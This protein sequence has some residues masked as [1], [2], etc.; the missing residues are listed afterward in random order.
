MKKFTDERIITKGCSWGL[1]APEVVS[2]YELLI[3]AEALELGGRS[4]LNQAKKRRPKGSTKI[5]KSVQEIEQ[6]KTGNL[7]IFLN[8]EQVE[9][10]CCLDLDDRKVDTMLF[11]AMEDTTLLHGVFI[12]ESPKGWHVFTDNAPAR[13]V[14]R[15]IASTGFARKCELLSKHVVF[16]EHKRSIFLQEGPGKGYSTFSP[17]C[18]KVG[19]DGDSVVFSSPQTAL[20]SYLRE[21][22]LPKNFK[23]LCESAYPEGMI[24]EGERNDVLFNY[25][26]DQKARQHFATGNF[27][28]KKTIID[29]MADL[30]CNPPYNEDRSGLYGSED[31][32]TFENF[33]KKTDEKMDSSWVSCEALVERLSGMLYHLCDQGT[34]VVWEN[35]T[36]VRKFTEAEVH[37]FIACKCDEY[38]LP[39]RFKP[40]ASELRAIQSSLSTSVTTNYQSFMEG[41]EG[42]A[43]RNGFLGLATGHLL[44]P[45]PEQ[46]SLG[47]VELDYDPDAWISR[48]TRNVLR[49]LVGG[50]REAL[51]SL[52]VMI[53]CCLS[54][55]PRLNTGFI[56]VGPPKTGKSSLL[57]ALRRALGAMKATVLPSNQLSIF[58]AGALLDQNVAMIHDL[59]ALDAELRDAVRQALGRDFL[60]AR[61]KH[62]PSIYFKFE[63]TIIMTSNFSLSELLLDEPD[64]GFC[65]RIVEIRCPFRSNQ[66]IADT[67]RLLVEDISGLINWALSAPKELLDSFQRVSTTGLVPSVLEDPI[68][69]FISTEF[70]H[71]GSVLLDDVSKAAKKFNSDYACE[72]PVHKRGPGGLFTQM[73][74]VFSEHFGVTVVVDGTGN[75]RKFLN[76]QLKSDSNPNSQPVMPPPS[77]SCPAAKLDPWV[78]A[79]PWAY[80]QDE[81]SASDERALNLAILELELW[82]EATE[83]NRLHKGTASEVYA[84]AANKYSQKLKQYRDSLAA[85]TGKVDQ[86]RIPTLPPSGLNTVEAN[87]GSHDP[88]GIDSRAPEADSTNGTGESLKRRFAG[89]PESKEVQSAPPALA[90]TQQSPLGEAN[91]GERST[92][93]TVHPHNVSS[94]GT[95]AAAEPPLAEVNT[96]RESHEPA[97]TATSKGTN[98][99]GN[100]NGWTCYPRRRQVQVTDC[101]GGSVQKRSR[102]R[103]FCLGCTLYVGAP[104][105]VGKRLIA[106]ASIDDVDHQLRGPATDVPE[107]VQLLVASIVKDVIADY[108]RER[109]GKPDHSVPKEIALNYHLTDDEL[110]PGAPLKELEDMEF[111]PPLNGDL[112]TRDKA[113]LSDRQ[114]LDVLRDSEIVECRPPLDEYAFSAGLNHYWRALLA[115]EWDLP[116]E[117]PNKRFG[118]G[119]LTIP[120]P[121]TVKQVEGTIASFLVA[122]GE[123]KGFRRSLERVVS[124]EK[125]L[126]LLDQLRDAEL[127]NAFRKRAQVN[128]RSWYFV[129][130]AGTLARFSAD[131]MYSPRA[132]GITYYARLQSRNEIR[133][134]RGTLLNWTRQYRKRF[135]QEFY[136]EPSLKGIGL[137]GADLSGCHTRLLPAFLGFTE[138]DSV[139]VQFQEGSLWHNV[140]ED[141]R[142]RMPSWAVLPET[143]EL[144]VLTKVLNYKTIQGG[145]LESFKDALVGMITQPQAWEQGVAMGWCNVYAFVEA[146]VRSKMHRELTKLRD[147]LSDEIRNI[148]M[149]SPVSKGSVIT[150][151]YG[152]LGIEGTKL[153]EDDYGRSKSYNSQFGVSAQPA[154]NSYLLT[155]YELVCI[156]VLIK[157]AIEITKK[158]GV[159]GDP[160]KSLTPVVLVQDG[161]YLLA[162]QEFAESCWVELDNNLREETRNMLGISQVLG[163]F[164]PY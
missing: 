110:V 104:V 19:A 137:F 77:S 102:F 60:V 57:E 22:A 51:N 6:A 79:L 126:G 23:W 90:G 105:A 41:P 45:K 14:Q 101:C 64:P 155:S 163:E 34:W 61:R 139:V 63:G 151:V 24:P 70:C 115:I 113:A 80:D 39:Y 11:R 38:N 13:R 158:R 146:F 145:K 47:A 152:P 16:L 92:T 109:A 119:G 82:Q 127:K 30:A 154:L 89:T 21:K 3:K 8:M 59:S 42:V 58:D 157:T 66:I 18:L 111:L 12:Q 35:G 86:D 36:W 135:C 121:K 76:V 153:F 5:I 26:K 87:S 123:G 44:P 161:V 20:T 50:S 142:K 150:T 15:E 10:L 112:S 85:D 69:R 17:G 81:V 136:N 49:L 94:P 25:T 91:L 72:L 108:E 37:V 140:H 96:L 55:R 160:Y 52:R 134:G 106:Q 74:T 40:G 62:L 143:N 117:L 164:E 124:H 147:L 1:D 159:V 144:K 75:R 2:F 28:D 4:D 100:A 31:R 116:A 83:L 68:A 43:F 131:Y 141:I 27:P 53:C 107:N 148:K 122:F 162:S 133:K 97:S 78:K 120:C 88:V 54:K 48:R 32:F 71:N 98:R 114:Y 128:R 29:L 67:S 99:V 125:R 95:S 65:D 7:S 129:R 149:K 9:N 56:L 103:R 156:M 46:R 93:G 84:E 73:V 132:S 118:F 33:E 138:E 130:R